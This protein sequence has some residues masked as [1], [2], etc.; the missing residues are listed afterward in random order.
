MRAACHTGQGCHGLSLASGGDENGL[1]IR[2]IFQMVN[3]DQCSLRDLDIAQFTGRT[4]HVNHASALND[5]LPV[6]FISGIDDLLHTV[7]VRSEGR[8]DDPVIFMLGKD[9]VKGLA[10]GTL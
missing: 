2:I 8:H 10:Y 3:I 6:I 1:L 5:H 4:D 7:Y 9:R